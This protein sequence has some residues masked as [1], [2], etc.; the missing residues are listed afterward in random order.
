L[1]GGSSKHYR[2]HGLLVES[3]IPLQAREVS[4]EPLDAQSPVPDYRVL[5]GELRDCPHS[6]PR[7]RILAELSDDRFGYWAVETRRDP[8][9][10]MLRYAGICDVTLDRER[11]TII[12]H[13]SPHADPGLIS[14]FLGG[15]VLA[16]VLTAEGLLVLHASAVEVEGRAIA[17]LG[18]SGTGKSTIAALLCTAGAR[19]V[20][21]DVLRVDATDSGPVCFP[22]TR[23]LRLRPAASSLGGGIE[24]A[25][26]RKTTDGRI[27]VIPA[28]LA[29]APLTL[30][31]ALVPEP[32]RE[33]ARLEARRLGAMEGL[34][35]L[36][37]HPRLT[38]WRAPEPIGKLFELTAE[39]AESLPLYRARIPWGPP[40]PAGLA[41]ELLSTV[42]RGAASRQS[43]RDA[44]ALSAKER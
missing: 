33:A 4:Q 27:A 23:G 1:S 34:Q 16:H 28:R 35:E 10:W 36:L 41:E 29:D 2:I 25:T 30:A 20:A 21:D 26:V 3:Q 14:I 38:M 22:G 24:G 44:G 32:S 13:R 19:L 6:P 9:L 17:I 15:S 5:E 40:F 8:V 31:G 12:V 43:D 37:R 42:V 39:I 11:K 7:G 18:P